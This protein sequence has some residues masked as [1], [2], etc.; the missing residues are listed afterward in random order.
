MAKLVDALD[1]KSGGETREGSSP[2]PGTSY[3][4]HLRR[5]I[6]LVGQNNVLFVMLNPSTA[7][8][9]VD[10]PTIRRCRGFATLM[11]AKELRVVNLFAARST[12]PKRLREHADPVG[13]DNDDAIRE[14]AKWADHIVAA[15]GIHGDLHGRNKQV[16]ELLADARPDLMIECL[17]MTDGGHP[18][19]PLYLSAE[20]KVIPLG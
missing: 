2:F 3:R 9:L 14:A 6:S 18:R 10:D 11:N 16:L 8:E 1:L 20:T 15:W 19:H 7:D 13:P 4:Y 17:G 5:F 12:D